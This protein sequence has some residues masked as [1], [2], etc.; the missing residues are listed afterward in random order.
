MGDSQREPSGEETSFSDA[1]TRKGVLTA[2]EDHAFNS[3]ERDR[4]NF[5]GEKR[6]SNRKEEGMTKHATL[7]FCPPIRG[8]RSSSSSR[9]KKKLIEVGQEGPI[10]EPRLFGIT[11]DLYW[12]IRGR[13]WPQGTKK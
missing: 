11:R 10:R 2:V 1:G 3:D 13:V 8:R 12:R 5:W 4:T 9:G 6:I 7:F